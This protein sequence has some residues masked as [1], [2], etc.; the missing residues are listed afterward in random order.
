M[1][2][3][4]CYATV[5]E[6]GLFLLLNKEDPE[7]SY[8]HFSIA[9]EAANSKE[10]KIDLIQYQDAAA[11][12][13]IRAQLEIGDNFARHGQ[14]G[15]ALETY[16]SIT[17]AQNTTPT[18]QFQIEHNVGTC[19]AQLSRKDEA[20]V[21]YLNAY[22]RNPTSMKTL[23]NIA[24][25]L[26]DIGKYSDAIIVFDEYLLAHPKSYSAMCGKS[27]CLK[28]LK[29]YKQSILVAEKAQSLDPLQK[30]DRCAQDL[31]IICDQEIL[32]LDYID[33][34]IV[35][36]DKTKVDSIVPEDKL[37][38]KAYFDSVKR[39]EIE[40]NSNEYCLPQRK[41]NGRFLYRGKQID[42]RSIPLEA[43]KITNTSPFC[44]QIPG[45]DLLINGTPYR[46]NSHQSY[47]SER[48]SASASSLTTQ[49]AVSISESCTEISARSKAPVD[50]NDAR[51]TA[52]SLLLRQ[53]PG[54]HRS[55]R[56][57]MAL[58]SD[59]LNQIQSSNCLESTLEEIAGQY[60]TSPLSVSVAI[61]EA[62]RCKGE[63]NINATRNRFKIRLLLFECNNVQK[64]GTVHRT[65]QAVLQLAG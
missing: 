50:I 23:K 58:F 56:S 60:V 15:S 1:E 34:R 7:Q 51:N 43:N 53:S 3:S 52:I 65:I 55:A 44:V 49:Q 17:N 62:D 24:I 29:L 5:V 20:L 27:G 38:M 28:D 22:K 2:L 26:A 32:K 45:N 31:K 10:K 33:S 8:K 19:L 63:N 46:I 14:Y 4:D 30:R 9:V 35:S 6:T 11:A 61:H 57:S 40:D 37:D 64:R 54:T 48:E 25:L 16:S 18:I 41:N 59:D 47:C 21:Y 39:K 36:K 12:V 42:H 13:L